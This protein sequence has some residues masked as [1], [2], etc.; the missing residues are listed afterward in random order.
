MDKVL[1][2]FAGGGLGSVGR[3]GLSVVANRLGVAG[4][5]PWATFC[6]NIIACLIFALVVYFFKERFSQN[7]LMLVTTG[8]C[9][10]LS[11]FSA[12]S[13][14]MVELINKQFYGIALLYI[15]LSLMACIGCMILISRY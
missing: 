9:G 1:L 4:V 10:G 8:F 12:F 7:M 15:A 11:T 5:F 6:A 14:E 2:V 13:F 3:Y